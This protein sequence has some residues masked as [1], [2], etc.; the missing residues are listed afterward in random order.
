[1]FY[2]ETHT[3]KVKGLFPESPDVHIALD[4]GNVGIVTLQLNAKASERAYIVDAFALALR[5][6]AEI[7]M[8]PEQRSVLSS[9]A[10]EY[11]EREKMFL[12]VAEE[13]DNL[14]KEV[15]VRTPRSA[16]ITAKLVVQ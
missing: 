5:L 4:W 11:N 1:M 2:P 8:T 16:H 7:N 9:V 6:G 12:Q 13:Q 10:K 15:P 14:E 3:R